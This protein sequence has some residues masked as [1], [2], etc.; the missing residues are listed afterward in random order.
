[1]PR[2]GRASGFLGA[3]ALAA[4]AARAQ[5]QDPAIAPTPAPPVEGEV[6]FDAGHVANLAAR[7]PWS[8]LRRVPGVLT[9]RVEVGGSG[10]AQ[11]PLVV[12]RGDAGSGTTFSLDGFDVTDPAAPGF[13][14]LFLDL[15]VAD[16]VAVRPFAGDLAGRG[17]GAQLRVS[18]PDPREAWHG[19]L[20]ARGSG[21]SLQSAN[22]PDDLQDLPFPRFETQRLR[23]WS[24]MAGGP[25]ARE[26]VS[27]WGAV[28]RQELRQQTPFGHGETLRVTS[29]FGRA[30]VALGSGRTSVLAVRSEKV[31]KDRDPTGSASRGALWRQSG[32]TSVLGLTDRRTL[33]GADLTTRLLWLDSG[34]SLEPRGR[35]SADAFEDFRG[36]FQ[37]SYQRFETERPRRAASLEATKRSRV[38]GRPHAFVVGAEYSRSRVETRSRWPGS[39]A[40]G[41]E[42]RT[43]FF[44]TFH[45]TGYAQLTQPQ[46]A[47][48]LLERTSAWLGN[49]VSL[50][51][52]TLDLGARLDRQVGRAL[53]SQV[54]ANALR[55]DL[56]P[57]AAFGGGA[58]LRW[59]DLLPRASLAWDADGEG[60][61]V[62]RLG[63]AAYGAFLTPGDAGF[64]NP[65]AQVGSR[66]WF[67][68]DD[69]GDR[70]VDGG[71]LDLSR[72][73]QGATLSS[74]V[75]DPGLAPP[76]THE[77]RLSVDLH[78]SPRWEAGVR[79]TW[80]RLTHPLWRPLQGLT[81]ADYAATTGVSGQLFG[82]PY[83]VAAYAPIP[84]VDPTTGRL[85]TN[86]DG[87]A[88]AYVGLD[89]AL[90]KRVGEEGLVSGFV[91][92]Q[93][94]SERFADRGAAI[95]DPT[96]RDTDPLRDGGAA[97]AQ[98]GGLERGD[99]FV[100]GRWSAGLEAH[101]VLPGDVEATTTLSLRDGFPVPYF[102]VALTSD[103]TGGA[104]NVLVSGRLDRF[105]MPTLAV[106]DVRLSRRF[107]AG[108]GTLTPALEIGNLLNRATTLQVARDVDLPRVG[109]PREI[110]RPR[111]VV[112]A[113][114]WS[115]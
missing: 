104:K 79:A 60:R 66:T 107:R 74:N 82:A 90:S 2:P 46:E 84:A 112:L 42:R 34:F 45:L 43:V 77:L 73:R 67:W 30:A 13:S 48:A 28:S 72:P 83:E 35:E 78:P 11:Q 92:V 21:A 69:D 110:L 12:A 36:V 8:L 76:R 80:R 94:W 54:A 65:L 89:L 3:L 50:G 20:Q 53:P 96:P 86:R 32:P 15:S 10:L 59:L 61:L 70:V 115:F 16:S 81:G 33:A 88:G 95:Q 9:D 63:Y 37:R 75:I 41:L 56:L 27:L 6:R 24:A 1:M 71:E 55:P 106:L 40:V 49:S 4:L 17:A 85:L 114:S 5:A 38:L 99:V 109:A 47:R 103:P 105:R 100:N 91:T 113:A 97:F 51:R 14:T 31:H 102:Q 26:R 64:A 25:L 87:Y 52:F 98:P 101:A 18:L 7:D 19:A 57:A 68:R 39:G 44:Q 29:G 22:L 93:D 62:T 58:P 23:E 108:R 111:S